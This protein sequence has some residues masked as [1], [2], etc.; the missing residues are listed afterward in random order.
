MEKEWLSLGNSLKN[1]INLAWFLAVWTPWATGFCFAYLILTIVIKK[2]YHL[3]YQNYETQVFSFSAVLFI[4]LS[5]KTYLHSKKSFYNTEDAIKKIDSKLGMNCQVIQAYHKQSEWPILPDSTDHGILFKTQSYMT[6]C[7]TIVCILAALLIPISPLVPKIE[8]PPSTWSEIQK[9]IDTMKNSKDLDQKVPKELQKKLDELKKQ[10][11]SKWFS[12]S[13]LEAAD[14]INEHIDGHQNKLKR[15]LQKASNLLKRMEMIRQFINKHQDPDDRQ[16]VTSELGR[17]LQRLQKE[18]DEETKKLLE[19]YFQ[20]SQKLKNQIGKAKAS[21]YDGPAQQLTADQLKKLIERLKRLKGALKGDGEGEGQGQSAPGKSGSGTI[22]GFPGINR[23]PG[24]GG[25]P[26]GEGQS[27]K[28]K[29]NTEAVKGNLTPDSLP[30]EVISLE[31]CK[32][33]IDTKAYKG[34]QKSGDSKN[35]GEGGDAVWQNHL[36]PE[37]Q[38]LLKRYFK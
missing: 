19:E 20:L 24:D 4:A 27:P 12:H 35:K 28:L 30:G 18:M 22:P 23:G 17:D 36:L 37:E 14:S 38:D 1:K 29:G 5:L 26:L 3:F 25:N 32:R 6:P 34:I 21:P 8:I 16:K 10:P 7:L 33:K 31:N 13:S 11:S 9:K 2:N 15:R